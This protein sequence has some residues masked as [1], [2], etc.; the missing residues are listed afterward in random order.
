MMACA[1]HGLS[2]RRNTRLAGVLQLLAIPAPLM[3]RWVPVNL[4]GREL[5]GY[6]VGP[7]LGEGGMGTVYRATTLDEGPAGPAGTTVA[8]KIF[9]PDLVTDETTFARCQ[10]EAELGMKIRHDHVVA[11]YEMSS[12]EL[13]GG[14]LH[15]L[16][17]GHLP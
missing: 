10:R 9:H 1:G 16:K 8:L 13:D 7:K 6:A 5:G 3:T 11:T 12:A 2:N 17:I 15:R 14:E 4:S